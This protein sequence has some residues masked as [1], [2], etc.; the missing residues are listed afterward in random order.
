MPCLVT[1]KQL[2]KNNYMKEILNKIKA[3][4]QAANKGEENIKTVI[5]CW[6]I[7]AYAVSYFIINKIIHL[8]DSRLFDILLSFVMIIYFVW[9]IYVVKKC[10]PKKP[11]LSNE[12]KQRIREEK[13]K[14]FKKSLLK[15]LLLQE[16]ITK[17]HTITVIMVMD[18]FC[19]AHF[20]SYIIR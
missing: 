11:K 13:R 20:L 6:G 15:K 12:E 7:L 14:N 9:H 3:S 2:I 10:S 5:W 16:S 1:K 8:I 4:F 17:W 18:A 19:V